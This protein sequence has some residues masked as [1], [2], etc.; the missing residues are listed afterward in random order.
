MSTTIRT[1]WALKLTQ[2][3]GAGLVPVG[4]QCSGAQGLLRDCQAELRWGEHGE[5]MEKM[6]QSRG[7]WGEAGRRR[8]AGSVELSS[9]R[10]RALCHP[11]T[12]ALDRWLPST[13]RIGLSALSISSLLHFFFCLHSPSISLSVTFSLA[14]SLTLLCLALLIVPQK[15]YH[16]AGGLM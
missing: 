11:D 7:K 5:T 2:P 14:R 3:S 4:I 12:E 6:F 16:F 10:S 9:A 13:L 15:S 1:G 8:G